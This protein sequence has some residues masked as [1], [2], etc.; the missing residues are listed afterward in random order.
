M[1][2]IILNKKNGI[3]ILLALFILPFLTIFTFAAD[4]PAAGGDDLPVFADDVSQCGSKPSKCPDGSME[5]QAT[6]VNCLFLEEP[7]GGKANWDLYKV[8]CIKK[9]KYTVCTTSL[10]NGGSLAA[11]EHGP[12]Q[13]LLTEDVSKQYQGPF[14]LLYSY[15]GLI[16]NYMSGLIIGISV[17]YVVIG[18]IQMSTSAGEE[19]KVTAGK[20]R[21]KKAILGLIIWFTASLILYTIN[22]T[23]FTFFQGP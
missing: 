8:I 17:L 21:I 19:G 4:P 18:G 20:D 7:I 16:Y 22:P 3:M 5:C 6:P 12:I 11:G 9:N 13:A 10:W 15:I 2:K 14:G 1:P 23:F